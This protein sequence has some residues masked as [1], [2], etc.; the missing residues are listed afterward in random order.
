MS[1]AVEPTLLFIVQIT[2]LPSVTVRM[3]HATDG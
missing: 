1:I 3:T 2:S